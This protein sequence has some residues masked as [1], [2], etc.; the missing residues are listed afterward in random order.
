MDQR[1]SEPFVDIYDFYRTAKILLVA[2]PLET[3]Q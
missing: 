1:I 2:I 3:N